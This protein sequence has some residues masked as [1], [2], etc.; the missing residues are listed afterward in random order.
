MQHHG[1]PTRLLDFTWSP[2][3]AAF[4]AL[5]NAS[6]EAAIWAIFP[7]GVLGNKFKTIRA[8]QLATPDDIG[9]WTIGNYERYFQVNENNI[10]VIGEPHRMNQRLIAQSGTF[11]MP[12]V[13]N[14]PIE[15]LVPPKYVKKIVIRKNARV[16][17]MRELYQM[18]ISEA[19]LFPGLDG[20]ARS[21]AFELESH[22]AFDPLTGEKYAGFYMD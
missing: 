13:L 21:L 20:L 22:W 14:T 10:V 1:A 19:T 4:F 2:Y 15:Q 8:D 9:P 17:A 3:V 6:E 12:G 11:A 5:Q 16:A 7:P 18:N